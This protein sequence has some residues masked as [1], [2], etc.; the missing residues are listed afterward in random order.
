VNKPKGGNMALNEKL[1]I[2]DSKQQ[3]RFLAG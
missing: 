3:Y 1:E 2:L